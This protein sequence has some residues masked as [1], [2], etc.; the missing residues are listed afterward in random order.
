MKFYVCVLILTV[1]GS[2]ACVQTRGPSA[3]QLAQQ[4]AAQERQRQ[5]EIAEQRQRTQLLMEQSE[6]RLSETQ[7]QIQQLRMELADR[8]SDEEIRALENRIAALEQMM[9]RMELQRAKDREEIIEIL[10]Q[11]MASVMAQQQ[12]ARV[13]A[14]GRSHEVARGET[15]SAIAAAYRVS[16]QSII[17]ANN[18]RDPNNLRVGQKLIIPGN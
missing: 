17:D 16:S 3:E 14:S 6:T 9:Q 10:S 12:S 2:S 11:R 1:L 7:G 15:L 13:Q 18:L 8:P 4:R 5:L